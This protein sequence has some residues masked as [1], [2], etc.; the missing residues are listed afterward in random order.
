MEWYTILAVLL[1]IVLTVALGVILAWILAGQHCTVSIQQRTPN[2][3]LTKIQ[4]E[5]EA[6]RARKLS[7][8]LKRTFRSSSKPQEPLPPVEDVKTVELTL[9]LGDG[10]R[11]NE[12]MT[13][14]NET[15]VVLLP[16]AHVTQAE[17]DE[18]QKK[19]DAI[20][21]KYNL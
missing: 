1:L 9:K 13:T 21:K 6:K 19:R 17:L 16:K 7:S 4:Q 5:Q 10:S 14:N 18:R 12:Q 2:V 8:R 20:R 15:A 11:R 3:E